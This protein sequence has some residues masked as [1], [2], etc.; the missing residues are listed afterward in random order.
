MIQPAALHIPDQ[1]DAQ[2][3]GEKLS[4]SHLEG[5]DCK[6]ARGKA[7]GKEHRQFSAHNQGIDQDGRDRR[8]DSQ[9]P[10]SKPAHPITEQGGCQRCSSAKEHVQR[11]ENVGAGEEPHQ[12]GD[13]AAQ[14]YTGNSYRRKNGQQ[15][16]RLSNPHLYRSKGEKGEGQTQHSIDGC[17]E[18]RHHQSVH[19]RSHP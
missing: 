7:A 14:R 17:N 12:V 15:G 18:G 13:K 8:R 3:T 2:S 5:L 10:D 1:I 16:K 11:A 19:A 9:S 6:D 4:R